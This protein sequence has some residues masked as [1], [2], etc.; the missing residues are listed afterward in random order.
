M[1]FK[2]KSLVKLP[3]FNCNASPAGSSGWKADDNLFFCEGRAA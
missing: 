1:V 2:K 3:P